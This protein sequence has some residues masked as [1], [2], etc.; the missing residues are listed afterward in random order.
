MSPPLDGRIGAGLTRLR[1][2][3]VEPTSAVVTFPDAEQ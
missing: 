1:L 3:P 2:E